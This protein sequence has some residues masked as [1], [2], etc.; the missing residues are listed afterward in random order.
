MT[1]KVRFAPSPT[2]YLHVGGLR[3]AL[4]NYLYARKTGG[5]IVLRIEDTDQ[6]RKVENAVEN[7]ITSFQNMKIHFDEGPHLDVDNFPYFQSMRLPLYKEYIQKLI[8]SG[9][10]Y[11]CFCSPDR[12]NMLREKLTKEKTTVKYYFRSPG[13]YRVFTTIA[14]CSKS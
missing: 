6:A 7:L 11:P 14:I 2:G 9:N 3:T 4:F 5:K 12:L 13:S 1:T 10:A 8:N